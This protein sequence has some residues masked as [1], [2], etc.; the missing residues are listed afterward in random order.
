MSPSVVS[1]D[2]EVEIEK[3]GIGFL[4]HFSTKR[5]IPHFYL[6]CLR[7]PISQCVPIDFVVYMG[8]G[9]SERLHMCLNAAQIAFI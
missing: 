4:N 8:S 1:S 5:V 9:N 3:S 2:A 6:T 7:K